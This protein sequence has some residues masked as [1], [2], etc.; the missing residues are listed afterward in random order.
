VSDLHHPAKKQSGIGYLI[1]S[2]G[3]GCPLPRRRTGESRYPV[4]QIHIPLPGYRLSPVR[5][6]YVSNRPNT[7]AFGMSSIFRNSG[8]QNWRDD[9]IH[10][11]DM[12]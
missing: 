4:P 5:Q 6:M 9:I 10:M 8:G 11:V 1:I 7:N 3:E 2:G 12:A